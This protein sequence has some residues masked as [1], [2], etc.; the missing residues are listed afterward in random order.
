MSVLDDQLSTRVEQRRAAR[1]HFARPAVGPLPTDLLQPEEVYDRDLFDLEMLRVFARSWIWLGDTEDLQAPGDYVTGTI[2]MQPV[3]VVRQDDGSLK[4]FLNACRHRASPIAL[5]DTGNCPKSFT[6][7]YHAWSY[8]HDGQL[9]SVPDRRRMYGRD[10]K[11]EDYG[12]VEIRVGVLFD[13]LVFGCLSRRQVSLEEWWAPLLSR[14]TRYGFGGFS[15]FHRDLDGTYPINWKAFMEN[16]NDDYHVRFVHA[17]LN[18]MIKR[19]DTTFEIAGRCCSGYKP[20]AESFD[21]TGGR[22]DLPDKDLHGFYAD[23]VYPNLSPLPSP[24]ELW[25]VRADPIAPD[26]TRLFSRVY[27]LNKTLEEQEFTLKNLQ[28]TNIEDTNM[29]G[30]TMANLRSPLYSVGPAS[31]WESRA[32]HIDRLVR[33]DVATPLADDEFR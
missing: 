27:G 26:R 10:F 4:G 21:G 32:I 23:A 8:A 9:L 30:M 28:D 24:T 17:R 25:M 14:Y 19:V 7:S 5:G 22:T 6:C 11:M 20:S 3:F 13:K 2:G 31:K 29:V 16:S 18:F 15:R 33:Q 12:L 1:D